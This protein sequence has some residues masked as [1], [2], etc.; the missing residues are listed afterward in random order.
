MSLSVSLPQNI[1]SPRGNSLAVYKDSVT[2]KFFV[3]DIYGNIEELPVGGGGTLTGSGTVNTV[4]IFTTSTNLGDSSITDDGIDISA[5]RNFISTRAFGSNDFSA[6]VDAGGGLGAGE[7]ALDVK[8][9]AY[10]RA[11]MVISPFPTSVQVDNS[12]LVIGSGSNDIVSGSD[13][14]LTV[15]NGNQIT[16]DSDRSVA[17]GN[18][19]ET[20][21][22]DNSMNVGNTNV[23]KY[24]NSSHIIGSNNSMG[25]DYSG[26]TAGL[27]NSLIIGSDNDLSTDDGTPTPPSG[28]LS[29]VIGHDND[30]RH[31]ENN[32]FSFGYSISN[33]VG[34]VYPTHR[35][36][37]NIGGDL[38][39]KNQTMTLGYR[40]D[41]Q[42]YPA[43]DR[44]NG[45]G[46]VKFVVAVGS[47]DN[48]NANAL[49]ITEGG[50]TSSG[51]E[52]QIP[53]IILP[54]IVG[55]N[56][57]D[58]SNASANGIPLG[59]LYHTAGAL[60]IRIT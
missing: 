11:G 29:F 22:S 12:S 42:L 10:V 34:G 17:F 47:S 4:P 13:H 31:T 39:L 58:D 27:Q 2:N 50:I 60:K 53:R 25:G 41:T 23:L 55:F 49:I 38:T 48:T 18:T 59:G 6:K 26:G 35:N 24:S 30:L 15:G 57:T 40:N 51:G 37:F 44:D 16:A 5:N 36:D 1:G 52:A 19:N 7:L 20:K 45:L 56:F 33:L 9:K 46:E 21:S 28:G 14:C 3:K 43:L 8:Q 54:T 32:S